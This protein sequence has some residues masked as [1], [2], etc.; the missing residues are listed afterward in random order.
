MGACTPIPNFDLDAWMNPP[1]DGGARKTVRET[2]LAKIMPPG[3]RM[4]RKRAV[5]LLEGEGFASQTAYKALSADGK[6][7][8][9]LVTGSDGMLS[10]SH[11]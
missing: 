2:H 1:E 7:A 9:R 6:F 5:E 3:T 11:D 8:D 10:W 4:T